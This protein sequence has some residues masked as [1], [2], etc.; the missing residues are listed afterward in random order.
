MKNI[1]ITKDVLTQ[2]IYRAMPYAE[3]IRNWNSIKD[4]N[5]IRFE[6]RGQEFRVTTSLSCDTVRHPFL[7]GSDIAIILESLLKKQYVA[8]LVAKT[9]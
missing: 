1:K 7:E 2:L 6:W 4:E 9:D 5:A 8:E 3:Q